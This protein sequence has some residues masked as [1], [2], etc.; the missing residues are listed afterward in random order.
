MI[1][2]LGKEIVVSSLTIEKIPRYQRAKASPIKIFSILNSIKP[3]VVVGIVITQES[4]RN[5]ADLRL[6]L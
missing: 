1:S 4:E 2:S 6:L 3:K 5:K